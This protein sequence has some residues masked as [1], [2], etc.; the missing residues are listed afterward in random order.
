MVAL[1]GAGQDDNRDVPGCCPGSVDDDVIPLSQETCPSKLLLE[2]L[3]GVFLKVLLKVASPTGVPTKSYTAPCVTFEPRL[4]SIGKEGARALAGIRLDGA[5]IRRH[6]ARLGVLGAV[7]SWQEAD[8]MAGE[9]SAH[10]CCRHTRRRVLG[11]ESLYSPRR[12][13]W[14]NEDLVVLATLSLRLFGPGARGSR[15]PSGDLGS[16]PLSCFWCFIFFAPAREL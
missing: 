9:G 16:A 15:S 3:L 4:I 11:R 8:R 1:P 14:R 12:R 6:G 7:P 5:G 13:S 10:S 2:L